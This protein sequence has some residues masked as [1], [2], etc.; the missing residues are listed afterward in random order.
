M[1]ELWQNFFSITQI[2]RAFKTK[3]TNKVRQQEMKKEKYK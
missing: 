1:K 3:E 2:K